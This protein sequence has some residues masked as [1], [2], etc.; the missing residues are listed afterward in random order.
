M[1]WHLL[2]Y[3]HLRIFEFF[4]LFFFFLMLL[5]KSFI[6][7]LV[8]LF[9]I[10]SI[11]KPDLFFFSLSVYCLLCTCRVEKK[12]FS[13]L[14]SFLFDDLFN[15]PE[16]LRRKGSV[17]HCH[18]MPTSK[19][20]YIKHAKYNKKTLLTNVKW[21][22]WAHVQST[23]KWELELCCGPYSYGKQLLVYTTSYIG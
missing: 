2:R 16:F 4:F 3:C 19:M 15:H 7:L 11:T 9:N 1:W 21:T 8:T 5:F 14:F 13:G 12:K 20:L 10:K 6:T 18:P 22:F 17:T 23:L